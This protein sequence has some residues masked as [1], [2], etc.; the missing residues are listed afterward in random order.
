MPSVT[1]PDG[2]RWPANS[3]RGIEHKSIRDFVQSAAHDGYLSGRVLDYGC[4]KRP[5]QDIVERAGG[6]YVG[7]DLEVYGGNV[8]M[9]DVGSIEEEEES[10]TAILCT[11]VVQYVLP[12]D[13]FGEF[14]DFLRYLLVPDGHL[15]ITYPTNWPEVES[16]DLYRF[17]KAG[18][19]H[20]LTA[21]GFKIIVHQRRGIGAVSLSGD[22]FALGYGVIARA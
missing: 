21:A 19:E 2:T 13:L 11:Q 7:Y 1:G 10:F 17:T 18:M 20:L 4:G 5:Y 22:E 9:E 3:L 16:A 15:V 8:S 6:E 12:E 14:F